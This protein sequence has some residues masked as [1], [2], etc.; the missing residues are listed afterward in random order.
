M[1]IYLLSLY[2]LPGTLPGTGDKKIQ[3]NNPWPTF[4]EEANM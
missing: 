4:V 1:N 2:Y 3:N